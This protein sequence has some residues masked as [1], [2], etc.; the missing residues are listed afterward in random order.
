MSMLVKRLLKTGFTILFEYVQQF[1]S[2]VIHFSLIF[3]FLCLDFKAPSI[4]L[5]VILQYSKLVFEIV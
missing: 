3:V 1:P 4:V 2:D 5:H